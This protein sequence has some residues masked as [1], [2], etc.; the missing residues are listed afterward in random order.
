MSIVFNPT[1]LK[2]FL[3]D[4]QSLNKFI[5]D[6]KE[7]KVMN[8]K[9]CTKTFLLSIIL[10]VESLIWSDSHMAKNGHMAIYGHMAIAPY[11]T[12]SLEHGPFFSK[13]WPSE[14]NANNFFWQKW[15]IPMLV[16]NISRGNKIL[17]TF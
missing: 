4:G 10:A 12:F 9:T 11:A 5:P 1:L 14:E 2:L 15:P 6:P 3:S 7:T 16:Q 17:K 8:V 13:W